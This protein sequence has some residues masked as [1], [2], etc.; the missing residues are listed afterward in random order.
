MPIL[1][2]DLLDRPVDAAVGQPREADLVVRVVVAAEIPQPIVVD[3]Q[4]LVRSLAI[5]SLGGVAIAMIKSAAM[6]RGEHT[7]P[8]VR[9]P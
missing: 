4:N 5:V 7:F 2:T 6:R 1:A 9:S 3:A 8:D